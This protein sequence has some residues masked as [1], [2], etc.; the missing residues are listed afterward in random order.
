MARMGERVGKGAVRKATKPEAEVAVAQ[1]NAQR[2][3]FSEAV[4]RG[5]N[6]WT[7]STR[8]TYL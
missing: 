2:T 4:T 1:A 5:R 8:P 7:V 3:K 6:C